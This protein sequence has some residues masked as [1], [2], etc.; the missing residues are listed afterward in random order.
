ME[1]TPTPRYPVDVVTPADNDTFRVVYSVPRQ[2]DGWELSDEHMPESVLHDE[3]LELL[4]AVLAFWV[5]RQ[6]LDAL[7]ARSL[8]VRWEERHPRI[9]L[10]PDIA[11]FQPA[12]PG[13]AELKSVR[14]WLEGHAPPVVAVEVVSNANPRK[15]YTI[16][17]DKYAASGA[18]ELLIFDPLLCGPKTHGGPFLL[19]L[20]Q[21]NARGELVRTY[22]GEGPVRS[23]H[24]G[25]YFIVS[26]DRRSLRL[27]EDAQGNVLW[28]TE[29]EA[30]RAENEAARARI[31][32]LE[33]Q[34]GRR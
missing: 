22:T 2:R 21:R 31:A 8:A 16:A 9:G 7:V 17:P 11:L 24:F 33:E 6:R 14:T 28:P 27:S 20:W 15:D 26:H 3:A 4:K 12:P 5:K 1:R 23:P 25:A 10:D 29:A 34:L 18:G 30:I 13:A 32:E 19:Q